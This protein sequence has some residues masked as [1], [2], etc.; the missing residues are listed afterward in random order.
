MS[1]VTTASTTPL[2]AALIAQR[3][4]SATVDAAHVVDAA[5]EFAFSTANDSTTVDGIRVKAAC[6]PV[7]TSAVNTPV[8]R[9]QVLLPGER[10]YIATGWGGESCDILTQFARAAIPRIGG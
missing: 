4:M 3:L 2:T 8:H 9:L 6:T 7:S 10:L 5:S 1:A